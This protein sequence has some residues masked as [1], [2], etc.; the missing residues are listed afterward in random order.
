MTT[1]QKVFRRQIRSLVIAPL[2]ILLAIVGLLAFQVHRLTAAQA[3]VDHTDVVLG[4]A[5]LLLRVIIDQETGLRGYLL[6]D[7]QHFLQPYSKAEQSLP[8]LFQQL[9]A[10]TVDNSTQ[11]QQLAVIQRSYE[12]WH[13]YAEDAI[14]RARRG[15]P[16]V[17]SVAFTL[18]GKQIM[19]SLRQ[20]QQIF[21]DHEDDLKV[22][23]AQSSHLA[24]LAVSWTLFGLLVIFALMLLTQTRR[25]IRLVDS[26]YAAILDNLQKRTTELSESRERLRVTLRSI[27]DGVIVTDAQGKV[28]FLNPVAEKLTQCSL[29]RAND[30]PLTQVFKIINEESRQTAESPFDKVMRHGTVVGLANH[31]ALV[32]EDGTEIS[33]DD[34][35]API[36]GEDGQIQG[37]VLVFRDVTGQKEMLK[38]LQM[39]EKL[40]AAG[41]LSAS[42]AHEIHNPLETVGNLLFLVRKQTNPE[43][44]KLVSMAEQELSRV[45]QITKNILSLYRESKKVV[46]L[47][48]SEIVD[49]V[50]LILQ[51]PI[52]D[53]QIVF[54]TRVLTQS[55]ISAFPAEM[56]QVVSNLIVNAVDAV[57]SGGQ[58]EVS[59][60]EVPLKDSKPGVML[61]V[62]DNGHGILQ[63]HRAKLF[64]PFFTTK[65]ENGT[66]LGLWITQGIIS[67]IGG[68]IEVASDTAPGN[69]GTTF[70]LYFPRLAAE[71]HAAD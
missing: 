41:K 52:R 49:S 2:I 70:K 61:M 1:S 20:Q 13:A 6:T 15:D 64:Q 46:P 5:R 33:I 66:G 50:S 36:R 65:G 40:A 3:W 48:L 51:R 38:V 35:G 26:E 37:V 47:K 34:S 14:A 67:K 8:G 18:T 43:L 25:S 9:N 19:D 44:Q 57:P 7:D 12:Q 45:V 30:K 56:R 71:A 29:D 63:E 17:N 16:E 27:G 42:I 24:E 21:V 62:R 23:R 10:G 55:L 28:T 32:R 53:K 58:I 54:S 4:Q 11:Q 69:H 59:I 60:E 68:Y 31:T 39:N 22:L